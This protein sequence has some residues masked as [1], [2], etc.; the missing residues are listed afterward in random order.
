MVFSTLSTDVHMGAALITKLFPHWKE[1]GEQF[2]FQKEKELLK[3]SGTSVSSYPPSLLPPPPPHF[4]CLS[5]LFFPHPSLCGV[6][7]RLEVSF[8]GKLTFFLIQKRCNNLV[9]G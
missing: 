1:K 2:Q 9:C 4:P 8:I 3:K 5:G 7:K 6:V